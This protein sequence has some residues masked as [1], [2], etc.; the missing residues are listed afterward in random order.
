MTALLQLPRGRFAKLVPNWS[1]NDAMRSR[2]L[3]LP[4]ERVRVLKRGGGTVLSCIWCPR[5]FSGTCRAAGAAWTCCRA[6][7]RDSDLELSHRN[8]RLACPLDQAISEAVDAG[9]VEPVRRPVS[10]LPWK[11]P[12]QAAVLGRVVGDTVLPH[13]PQNTHP[14]A[15]E[16]AM[17]CG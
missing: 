13:P 11:K 6:N 1:R 16:D 8:S 9:Q 17:A 5:S 12:L 4:T 10:T 2:R 15:A 14:G 3:A 7:A